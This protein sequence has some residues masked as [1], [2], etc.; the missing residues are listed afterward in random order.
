MQFGESL[1]LEVAA[2]LNGLTPGDVAL[3]LVLS[4]GEGTRPHPE[5]RSFP[6]SPAGAGASG[7]TR[8][9]LTLTPE[10]CG[11]L[12]YRIRLYPCHPALTHPF[13]L[14]LMLWA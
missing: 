12:D 13:E 4:R 14:G 11:Q 9:R 2:Q 3:E 8:F 7:E 1:E 6:F 10:L 5:R